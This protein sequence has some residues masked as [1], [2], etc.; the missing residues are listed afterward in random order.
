M[1]VVRAESEWPH[2]DEDQRGQRDRPL[3]AGAGRHAEEAHSGL[4]KNP[5]GRMASTIASTMK[6]T[7][8]A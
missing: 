3:D 5:Y 8:I 2:G 6:V 1:A 4:P 7:M